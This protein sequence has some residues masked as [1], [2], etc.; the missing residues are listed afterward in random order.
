MFLAYSRPTSGVEL[1]GV[2]RLREDEAGSGAEG[3]GGG[4][5]AGGTSS[6]DLGGTSKLREEAG[7]VGNFGLDG[8]SKMREKLGTEVWAR[9]REQVEGGVRCRGRRRRAGE[10]KLRIMKAD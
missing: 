2:S 1:G 5:G 10:G 4:R 8:A 7:R 6:N 3:G 9:R